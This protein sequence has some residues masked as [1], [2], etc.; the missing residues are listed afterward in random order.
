LVWALL[1]ALGNLKVPYLTKNRWRL[2]VTWRR[3]RCTA[4]ETD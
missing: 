3:R 1:Q 4:I 2:R